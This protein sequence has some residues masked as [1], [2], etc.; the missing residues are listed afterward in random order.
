MI[1][2]LEFIKSTWG[3]KE[4]EFQWW[5]TATR[6]GIKPASAGQR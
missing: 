1:A 2:I 3:C 5:M 4:R 6:D